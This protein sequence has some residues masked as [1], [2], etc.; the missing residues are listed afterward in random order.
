[1]VQIED[2]KISGY[3]KQRIRIN[4]LTGNFELFIF[5]IYIHRR[6]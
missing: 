1:M 5:F 6:V 3:R 2:K 4:K